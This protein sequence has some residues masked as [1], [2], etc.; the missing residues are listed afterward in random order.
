[1]KYLK[2]SKYVLASSLL[3]TTAIATAA[4]A[5]AQ[6][7][8]VETAATKV[9][10]YKGFKA[11]D[12][13]AQVKKV[14]KKK[15]WKLVE[16]SKSGDTLT[17]KATVYNYATAVTFNFNTGKKVSDSKLRGLD[18][19]LSHK[20]GPKKNTTNKKHHQYIVNKIKKDFNIKSLIVGDDR[21]EYLQSFF[22]GNNLSVVIDSAQE[23]ATS[24][25]TITLDN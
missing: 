21:K 20:K 14:A 25:I 5:H 24:Y 11:N 16:A 10:T 1:M 23:A 17:Y 15:G 3:F 19:E 12:S 4:P 18:L 8:T 9:Y 6:T 22:N 7:T 13:I 2:F